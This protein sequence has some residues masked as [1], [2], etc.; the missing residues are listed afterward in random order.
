MVQGGA[1]SAGSEHLA[2]GLVEFIQ[3]NDSLKEAAESFLKNAN[4]TDVDLADSEKVIELLNCDKG[5]DFLDAIL[6]KLS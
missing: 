2:Q 1:T 3:G 5:R 6:K 4:I